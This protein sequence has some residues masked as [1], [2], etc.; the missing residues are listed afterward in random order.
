MNTTNP[1][2]ALAPCP[3]Y[4]PALCRAALEKV[5]SAAGGL[6][7]V[8][9]GMRIGIKANLVSMMKPEAAA[10]THPELLKA[11]VDMIKERGAEPVV[12]DS[13]GGLYNAVYVNRVYHAA[14]MHLTGAALNDDYS[15]REVTLPGAVAAKT[16]TVTGWLLGCDGIIN[17]CK[18]KSHG[19]MGMSAA[20]KNLFGTIPGTMKPE[21]HY[22]YPNPMDFANMLVDLDEYWKPR[23]HLVDAVT[24]MEGNGPTAGTPR[25]VGCVLAGENPHKIDLL[26]AKLIGLEPKLIPTLVAAMD[27][28]LCPERV[29]ELSVEG[30]WQDF[31]MTD[32]ELVKERTGLQFQSLMGGGKVGELFSKFAGR[33]IASRPKVNRDECVGCKKCCEI[34]PAKAI[35]MKNKRPSIDRKKCIRCFC[36]QEFCPKGAMKVSRPPVARILVKSGEKRR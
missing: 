6:D 18:L 33:V 26:C 31:L 27:R 36:C 8:K 34:C 35:T 32:F 30:P 16:A 12:G 29:E 21:Y 15:T 9:P 1:D 19:M 5:V 28:G 25:H 2:V 23:L 11:L 17:F 3:D 14:G 22:R 7:W 4:E 10:T 20:A 13:P 24:A